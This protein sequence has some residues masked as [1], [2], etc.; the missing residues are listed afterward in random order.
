MD[1][2][3]AKRDYY[4]QASTAKQRGIVWSLTYQQWLAWWQA[5]LGPDWQAKRGRGKGLYCMARK[6]DVGPYALGNIKCMTFSANV[7][8][9]RT[10]GTSSAGEKHWNTKL[11]EK[12]AIAVRRAKGTLDQLAKRF[13]VHKDTIRYI[14]DGSLWSHLDTP[15]VDFDGKRGKKAKLTEEQVIEI[16][17]SNEKFRD[18]GIKYGV[19]ESNIG[20]IK[21]GRSWAKVTSKLTPS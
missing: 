4:K 17:L 1:V 10:N 16:Y 3:K 5:K 6:G 21:R 8:E 11:T 19:A 2:K 12:Q 18:L 7:S 9:M 13:E 14:K 15:I 20:A